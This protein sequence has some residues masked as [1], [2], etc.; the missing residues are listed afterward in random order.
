MNESREHLHGLFWD[1]LDALIE[2]DARSTESPYGLRAVE[3]V[4]CDPVRIAVSDETRR[5]KGFLRYVK[6]ELKERTEKL[7]SVSDEYDLAQD[8]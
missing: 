4:A 8:G 2:A 7:R 6:K 1:Y 3:D 5:N